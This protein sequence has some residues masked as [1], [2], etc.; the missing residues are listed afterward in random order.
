M[1]IAGLF[2]LIVLKVF[3]VNQFW[4]LGF[5]VLFDLQHKSLRNDAILFDI[6]QHVCY[7]NNWKQ[8]LRERKLQPFPIFLTRDMA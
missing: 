3:F 5:W 8:E 1:V 2:V 4:V 6:K 7:Q